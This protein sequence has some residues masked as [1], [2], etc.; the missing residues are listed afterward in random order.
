MFL[1]WALVVLFLGTSFPAIAEEDEHLA[2]EESMLFV[3]QLQSTTLYPRDWS[4]NNEICGFYNDKG[5]EQCKMLISNS[6]GDEI[7]D[8]KIVRNLVGVS[9]NQNIKLKTSIGEW[10]NPT[11]GLTS[12]PLVVLALKL[13]ETDGFFEGEYYVY[14]FKLYSDEKLGEY[15][16][17]DI[18]YKF[19]YCKKLV[20]MDC[21][22]FLKLAEPEYIGSTERDLDWVG[23][24]QEKGLLTRGEDGE[25]YLIKAIFLEDLIKEIQKKKLNDA[26][27]R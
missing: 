13:K 27:L 1:R 4:K 15:F 2:F 17:L 25:M 16:F 21:Y 9:E 7:M 3:G 24:F 6:C 8:F 18:P 5:E 20:G 19:E 14:A 12:D 26:G 10:C 11:I 22:Q 23:D